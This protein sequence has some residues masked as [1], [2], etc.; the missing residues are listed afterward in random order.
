MFADV[1]TQFF[2]ILYVS[3]KLSTWF[4]FLTLLLLPASTGDPERSDLLLCSTAIR[5]NRQTD[6][7]RERERERGAS[8]ILYLLYDTY[9]IV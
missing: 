6:G 8:P 7:E 3:A 1:H 4:F 2:A 5:Q 9:S